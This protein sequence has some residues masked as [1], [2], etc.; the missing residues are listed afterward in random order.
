MPKQPNVAIY[1]P[2]VLVL[3][4]L[5]LVLAVLLVSGMQKPRSISTVFMIMTSLG[6]LAALA[7]ALSLWRHSG[8]MAL[9]Y[10]MIAVSSALTTC[11]IA[12]PEL[13]ATFAGASL[14]ALVVAFALMYRPM[15]AFFGQR[16]R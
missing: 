13:K 7:A 5:P 14:V 15:A 16:R 2:A 11:G 1:A 4:V 10:L 6:A 3:F 9:G 12:A 8:A